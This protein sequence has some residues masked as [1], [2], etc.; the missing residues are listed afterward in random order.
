MTDPIIEQTQR[1]RALGLEGEFAA[2]R[3]ILDEL[4]PG[5]PNVAI[6]RGRLLRTAGDPDAAR[7]FFEAAAASA[8]GDLRVDAL[9][10]LALVA[11]LDEQIAAHETA[12]REARDSAPNWVASLLNNLGMTYSELGDWDAALNVFEQALAEREQ[13][14]D[15]EATRIAKWMIAWTLRNLGRRDEA[16]AMQT[17]LKSELDA[18]GESDPY[19]EEE[20]GLLMG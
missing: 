17:A 13:R 1:A 4:P 10:M 20:L 8:A 6:E 7:P 5:H 19:V 14:D 11:P 18:L 9:H 2:A 12:L 3:A 16:L 15:P